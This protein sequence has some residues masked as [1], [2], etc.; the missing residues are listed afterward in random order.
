M[1]VDKNE[2]SA[3]AD[4]AGDGE[5]AKPTSLQQKMVALSG[6][7]VDDFMK[8]MEVVQK[9]LETKDDEPKKVT[10]SEPLIPPGTDLIPQAA[11]QTMNQQ[12]PAPLLYPAPS[13]R[14]PPGPPPGRP[15]LPPGPPPGL[16]PPRMPMRMPPAPP[17][18]IR[19]VVF[20]NMLHNF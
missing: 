11:T 9:K 13:L 6:Q 8:E 17:R 2:T 12:G 20:F 5:G 15:L 7:N 16:P 19:L 3:I 1:E 4:D 10:H 14:L 18:M